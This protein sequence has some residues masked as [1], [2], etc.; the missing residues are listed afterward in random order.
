MSADRWTYIMIPEPALHHSIRKMTRWLHHKT[1]VTVLQAACLGTMFIAL[2]SPW[3]SYCLSSSSSYDH[4][5]IWFFFK[6]IRTTA[7]RPNVCMEHE[8]KLGYCGHFNVYTITL[9]GIVSE[10]WP[11]HIFRPPTKLRGHALAYRFSHVG[12]VCICLSLAVTCEW[13]KTGE[14][15]LL[16]SMVL[17]E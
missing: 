8:Y 6:S 11:F 12:R 9:A 10:I 3:Q 17:P 2:S 13:W 4:H 15:S 5:Q 1:S 7:L 14:S 16:C